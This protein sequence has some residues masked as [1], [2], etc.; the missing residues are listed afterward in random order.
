M[1]RQIPISIGGKIQ[2]GPN[3]YPRNP[4]ANFSVQIEPIAGITVTSTQVTY[5]QNSD[6]R[7][8]QNMHEV[9]AVNYTGG[10]SSLITKITGAGVGGAAII[11]VNA[12][13]A[14]LSAG[15]I[16]DSP[17][18]SAY[19]TGDTVSIADATGAGAIFTVVAASGKITGLTY[20]ANSAIATAIDPR[21]VLGNIYVTVGTTNVIESTSAYELFR[22]LFNKTPLSYG[23]FPIYFR[24]PWRN[25]T[26][27][28]ANTWDMAGQGIFHTKF[29]INPGYLLVNVTGTM[30][31]DYVR[32]TTAGEID[33]VTYQS[34]VNANNF[35]LPSLKIISRQLLTMTMTGG[36]YI[37]PTKDIPTGWPILRLHYFDSNPN[38]IYNVLMKSDSDI[39]L[40][41]NVGTNGFTQVDQVNEWLINNDF[42]RSLS[43]TAPSVNPDFSFV[44]DYDQ[45]TANA[46][47][48]ASV[49]NTFQNNGGGAITVL[50]E[51]LQSD[52]S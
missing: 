10:V 26:G 40:N 21:L 19:V 39:R 11:T 6:R 32:N 14:P 16:V 51:A 12:T 35:P 38:A 34:Y 5:T 18:M 48:C 13:Q 47:K 4:A 20:V 7:Y 36:K 24:E 30:T 52:F 27:S 37:M 22:P 41:G 44:A 17:T 3:I 31:Y 25:L 43:T 33:Q 42:N 2:L 1:A 49:A 15:T 50:L 45:R 23:Q 46:L 28:R 8:H 29:N 9:V